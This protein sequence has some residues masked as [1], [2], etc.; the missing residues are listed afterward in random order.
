MDISKVAHAFSPVILGLQHIW[1]FVQLYMG[2]IDISILVLQRWNWVT[3][4]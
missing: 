1:D 4:K 2:Q 3:E